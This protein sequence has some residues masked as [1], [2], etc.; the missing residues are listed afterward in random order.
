M[1]TVTDT[2][3]LRDRLFGR[4]Q[5]P[6]AGA[7]PCRFCGVLVDRPDPSRAT[8]ATVPQIVAY[9]ILKNLNA[10]IAPLQVPATK[11]D[12]CTRRRFSA[13]VMLAEHPRVRRAHGMV[14]VDRLDAALATFDVLGIRGFRLRRILEGLTST[15]AE[16]G[17]LIDALAHL[18][19]ASAWTA[20]HAV[21]D[22]RATRRWEHVSDVLKADVRD[23]HLRLFHRAVE[24]TAKVT[25]P[26]GARGCL[27][28]GVGHVLGRESDRA[29]LWG[30]SIQ[31]HPAALNGRWPEVVTGHL[32]PTCRAHVAG[33]GGIVSLPV[34]GAALFDFLGFERTGFGIK[35]REG[36]ALPWAMERPCTPPNEKPW[37][38]LDLKAITRRLDNAS[39]VR[40]R[41]AS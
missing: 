20:G 32:C 38:H 14:A 28:C 8:L 6:A 26:I 34:A 11:C 4:S 19:A 37:T 1:T 21:A 5:Q 24:V 30:P 12:D 13:E 23:A 29:D 22:P 15:D 27:M 33:A 41:T 17:D 18:G 36:I 39:G 9:S 3:T 7:L 40:R 16:L 31:A 10:P 35:M 25:P 2:P